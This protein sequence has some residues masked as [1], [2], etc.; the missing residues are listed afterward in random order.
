MSEKGANSGAAF[1]K[2]KKGGMN[3]AFNDF[4]AGLI[5]RGKVAAV[6]APQ[7]VPSGGMA[8]P[9]LISDPEKIKTDAFAPV[10]PVAT[11][12]MISALTCEA[13]LTRRVAAVMPNCQIRALIELVKLKQADIGNI[14]IIGIDCPGVFDINDYSNLKEDSE[15]L[16][17][18]LFN[19]VKKTPAKIRSACATCREPIPEYC[20]IAVG[21]LGVKDGVMLEPRTDK[22]R[23]ALDG[24]GLDELKDANGR[25]K[26][27]EEFKKSRA[28]AD[29]SFRKE[30]EKIQGIAEV[31]K[32]YAACINCQNCRT[33]CPICYCH[34][35]FFRSD[36]LAQTPNTLLAKARARGS[37]K[38][39]LDTLLF[40]TGRMNHMILS[41]VEC[42]LC[43]QA[44]PANIPLMQVLKRVAA[45]A[46]SKF[47]YIPGRHPDEE[48]PLKVFRE[49]EFNNVGEE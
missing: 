28:A 1:L 48:M 13:P 40:H 32:F 34:E 37:F 31:T 2:F 36:N 45:D 7:Q 39:P 6:L 15:T 17:T 47:N 18:A 14:V 4:L 16:F 12:K 24:A 8:F 30:H 43:E 49:D 21:V 38:M 23:D 29:E 22:G 44:C 20:D 9:A 19:N 25:A 42:G 26:A 10:L 11:A 35:C 41:C 46:Q 27:V 33:V 3:A 5:N